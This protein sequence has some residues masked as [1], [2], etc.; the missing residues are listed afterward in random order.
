MGEELFLAC[1][2][3]KTISLSTL[4]NW[5]L[6]LK[7]EDPSSPPFRL[8]STRHAYHHTTVVIDREPSPSI[9]QE[10]LFHLRRAFGQANRPPPM[11]EEMYKTD[12]STLGKVLVWRINRYVG[13][14]REGTVSIS[15]PLQS[16]VAEDFEVKA[17]V[18]K[19]QGIYLILELHTQA[20]KAHIFLFIGF[21]P[22]KIKM[23]CS[24]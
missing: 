11:T 3:G 12:S 22:A 7:G 10:Y 16:D 1:Y 19:F 8:D 4:G 21:H 5:L 20:E 9:L 17:W 14:S 18:N 13:L 2:Q 15:W 6:H 24:V 23:H